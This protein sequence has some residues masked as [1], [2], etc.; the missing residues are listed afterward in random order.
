MSNV[1]QLS[2]ALDEPMPSLEDP[3]KEDADE[4][5]EAELAEKASELGERERGGGSEDL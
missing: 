5:E 2:D 1:E 3:K 4:D